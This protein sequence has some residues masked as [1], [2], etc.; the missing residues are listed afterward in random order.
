MIHTKSSD[1]EFV[2]MTPDADTGLAHETTI[3]LD[4]FAAHA[5][6]IS[7]LESGYQQ[8][9]TNAFLR[10]VLVTCGVNL[11]DDR[12]VELLLSAI[13]GCCYAAKEFEENNLAQCE[14]SWPHLAATGAMLSSMCQISA[15]RY[16]KKE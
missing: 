1:S 3:D 9:Q 6:T 7:S 12:V 10:D 14:Q 5:V 8:D 4:D 16:L 13:A 2:S 15:L 11:N